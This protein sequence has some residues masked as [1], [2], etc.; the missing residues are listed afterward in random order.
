VIILV[1]VVVIVELDFDHRHLAVYTK[2]AVQTRDREPG[3]EITFSTGMDNEVC[4]VSTDRERRTLRPQ[5]NRITFSPKGPL[6]WI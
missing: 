2:Y 1:V 6:R 3:K 4:Y 5:E